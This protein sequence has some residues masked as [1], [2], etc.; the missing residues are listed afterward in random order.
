M[1]LVIVT[2]AAWPLESST[3]ESLR[4]GAPRII[5]DLLL[6]ETSQVNA[7]VKRIGLS[8]WI[9]DPAFVVEVLSD[10]LKI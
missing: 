6:D 10:L 8:T 4:V 2:A 7:F 1:G 5:L 3:Q 9:T